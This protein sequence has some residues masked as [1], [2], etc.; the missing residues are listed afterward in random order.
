M[1]HGS[2]HKKATA[3]ATVAGIGEVTLLAEFVGTDLHLVISPPVEGYVFLNTDCDGSTGY[4]PN[5][6]A[7][8]P[9]GF[10]SGAGGYEYSVDL[11]TGNIGRW[12]GHSEV[13]A[14]PFAGLATVLAGDVQ[15]PLAAIG[16]PAKVWVQVDAYAGGQSQGGPGS[17]CPLP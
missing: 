7:G 10:T 9:A 3:S 8:T 2:S 1:A 13:G 11:A 6:P 17:W 4:L 14:W 12:D 16:N 15:I 5:A